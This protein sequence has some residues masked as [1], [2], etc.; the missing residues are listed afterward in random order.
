MQL[1]DGESSIYWA[2]GGMMTKEEM[3]EVPQ[4]EQLLSE[5]SVLFDNGLG[6]VFNWLLLSV[7]CEKWG[8]EETGDSA[9][10]FAA[11]EKA[12]QKPRLTAEQELQA[13]LDALAGLE[14]GN[15]Q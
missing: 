12:M 8:V 1:Y 2:H 11:L 10:D 3:E 9:A 15:E 4:L 5:P 6:K 14:N 7:L 13:Q